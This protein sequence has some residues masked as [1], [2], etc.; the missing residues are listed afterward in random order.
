MGLLSHKRKRHHV[1]CR[2]RNGLGDNHTERI[3]LVSEMNLPI[4]LIC[5][6]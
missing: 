2:K 5:G 6:S 1:T 4:A 3:K